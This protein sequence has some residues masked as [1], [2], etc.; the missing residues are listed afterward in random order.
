MI[1]CTKM[2][3]CEKAIRDID[4]KTVSL[5]DLIDSLM[6]S[7]FPASANFTVYLEFT[8]EN[9]DP[10]TFTGNLA[11]DLGDREYP[12]KDVPINFDDKMKMNAVINA[13]GVPIESSGTMKV[14]FVYHNE[15]LA[16]NSIL[17]LK[18][19]EVPN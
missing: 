18:N 14:S 15:T 2:I 16:L 17:I 12:A 4:T 13:K 6:V 8:R 19:D 1:K 3:V 9:G 7:G 10:A 11:V 5:I